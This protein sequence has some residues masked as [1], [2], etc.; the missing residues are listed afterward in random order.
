MMG[1]LRGCNGGFAKQFVNVNVGDTVADDVD[2]CQSLSKK[3][4]EVIEFVNEDVKFGSII[5]VEDGLNQF[6][7]LL[8]LL[9]IGCKRLLLLL[10]LLVIGLCCN[11]TE[12]NKGDKSVIYNVGCN[13]IGVELRFN[14]DLLITVLYMLFEYY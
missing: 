5:I 4:V 11:K 3:S 14:M 10:L 8:L 12:L 13:K 2:G 9:F 1:R 6:H 7:E